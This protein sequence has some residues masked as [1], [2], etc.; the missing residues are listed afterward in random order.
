MTEDQKKH[1]AELKRLQKDKRF[2]EKIDRRKTQIMNEIPC[3][4]EKYKFA[5]D[6]ENEKIKSFLS[7][8]PSLTPLRPDFTKLSFS[9]SI[10]IDDCKSMNGEVWLAFLE[11]DEVL[12]KIGV[13]GCISDFAGD[14]DDWICFGSY[15]LFLFG[16]MN[17]F[18]F[19]DDNSEITYAQIF[20][21]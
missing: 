13:L 9:E 14:I 19:I 18:I 8:I 10:S 17:S 3:F 5:D 12:L 1:A 6:A 11:G 21:S 4:K 16:D 2:R 20:L 15:M 7:M